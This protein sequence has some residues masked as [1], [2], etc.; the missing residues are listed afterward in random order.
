M[1]AQAPTK[2]LDRTVTY[3]AAS[4]PLSSKRNILKIL[5]DFFL[6]RVANL[7]LSVLCKN[8]NKRLTI[9]NLGIKQ[10]LTNANK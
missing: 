8:N 10:L 5:T 9:L 2:D 3:V 7:V 6:A 1:G 4:E